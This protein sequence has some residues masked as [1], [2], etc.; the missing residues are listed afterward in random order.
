MCCPV[1]RQTY[2][3]MGARRIFFRGGQIHKRSVDFL[4]GAL[5]CFLL[6]KV[7]DFL[8]VAL[9]TQTKTTE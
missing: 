2:A 8:V 9:K 1:C 6:K 7:D 4:W 3:L 5:F